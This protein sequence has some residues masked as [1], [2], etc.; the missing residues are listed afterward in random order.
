MNMTQ[1]ELEE[2]RPDDEQWS[3]TVDTVF[4]RYPIMQS[5]VY[6]AELLMEHYEPALPW[7]NKRTV[8][9]NQ[10]RED[11]NGKGTGIGAGSGCFYHSMNALCEHLTGNG[12]DIAAIMQERDGLQLSLKLY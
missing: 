11:L 1:S 10:H 2:L 7:F 12:I 3:T 5:Y 8:A 9:V 6:K 4:S